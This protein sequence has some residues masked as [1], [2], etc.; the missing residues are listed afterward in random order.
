[1]G[2]IPPQS[3]PPGPPYGDGTPYGY[4][5]AFGY[6]CAYVGAG[7]GYD[8]SVPGYGSSY[9]IGGSGLGVLGVAAKPIRTDPTRRYIA[10]LPGL[11]YDAE[12]AVV[13]SSQWEAQLG[14]SAALIYRR[15]MLDPQVRS[16]WNYFVFAVLG[17]GPSITPAI[18]RAPERRDYTA[19]QEAD[20][21]L[22][23]AIAE[24][25]RRQQSRID[26][27]IVE[28]A[29]QF[30]HAAAYK[31]MLAEIVEEYCEVGPDAG[32][33]VLKSLPI[34]SPRSW[35][36]VVNA[37]SGET[38]GYLAWTSQG[39]QVVAPEHCE[40]FAWEPEAGDPRGTSLFEAAYSAW[41][42]KVSLVPERFKH[43]VLFG[44]PS[45]HYELPPNAQPYDRLNPD[46][47]PNYSLPQISPV[48]QGMEQAS[49]F[50]SGGIIVT[51][52]GGKVTIVG[53]QD[54]GGGFTKAKEDCNREIATAIL[55]SPRST[56]EA[57]HGS[58]ADNEGAQDS[59]GFLIQRGKQRLAAVFRAIYKRLV[60]ANWGQEVAD[61]L[62][63]LVSFSAEHHDRNA[64]IEANVKAGWKAD[65]T[66]FPVM[67][68]QAGLPVRP[69]VDPGDGGEI[70]D[71]E[72][73]DEQDEDDDEPAAKFAA[74]G[75]KKKRRPAVGPTDAEH[76]DALRF[77]RPIAEG[78]GLADGYLAG[79]LTPE[80]TR[81][82]LHAV[83][84]EAEARMRAEA[85]KLVA[86]LAPVEMAAFANPIKRFFQAAGKLLKTAFLAAALVLGGPAPFVADERKVFAQQVVAQEAF[87]KNFEAE[88]TSG[89]Q[90]VGPGLVNRAGM[91]GQATWAVGQNT[92]HGVM[93][94]RGKTEGR[95]VL[96]A[97]DDRNCEECPPLAELGWVPLKDVVP[98]G[99]TACRVNCRCWIEYRGKSGR[100]TFA[101][102]AKAAKAEKSKGGKSGKLGE[103][104]WVTHEG[105][106]LF[107]RGVGTPEN[108]KAGTP[109]QQKHSETRKA[110]AHS[111]RTFRGLNG[112]KG[113]AGKEHNDKVRHVADALL[114]RK[115]KAPHSR[116]PF[117]KGEHA[118]ATATKKAS[119]KPAKTAH[120]KATVKAAKAKPE[121]KAK[122]KVAEAGKAKPKA[123]KST[124]PPDKR[125]AEP[126]V[127][128][129]PKP[130]AT[131]PEKVVEKSKPAEKPASP[132]AE[133]KPYVQPKEPL[134]YPADMAP[135]PI[136]PTKETGGYRDF[137]SD[138]PAME[139]FGRDSSAA[140][141]KSLSPAERASIS[142]YSGSDYNLINAHYRD[143][144]HLVKSLDAR[145]ATREGFVKS[146]VGPL[147][148][149][150]L[151]ARTAEP[152][153]AYRGI[154]DVRDIGIDLKTLKKGS[155]FSEP[156]PASTSLKRETAETFLEDG[157]LPAILKI[158][159]PKGSKAAYLNAGELS[160]VA[161]E[162]ELLI[163]P[164]AAKYKVRKIEYGLE[165]QLI[166]VDL[167]P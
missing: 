110:L 17:D 119:A 130:K 161:Q 32:R 123:E 117:V 2:P 95:R 24:F 19:E 71:D 125:K 156:A 143:A 163:A 155:T 42:E 9:G 54:D 154:R 131:K 16:S 33:R 101:P 46:G 37:L 106:H 165:H 39:P 96:G 103:G 3:P 87:L 55:L 85:E 158:H 10:A 137:G 69:S 8:S 22:A 31:A 26:R 28:V 160:V 88:V 157:T 1:M 70:A 142:M 66:A 64:I 7:Y 135:T 12:A 51:H 91:Y 162:R 102:K 112:A 40:A 121:P 14:A 74:K 150:L 126:G 122:A 141:A 62:T 30:L 129:E 60:V 36:F 20:F 97:E 34:R 68:V 139:K 144:P 92:K 52:N 133:K 43:L 47:T 59:T 57:E 11:S 77:L 48:E 128:P 84:V 164:G 100:A 82:L 115:P 63:P 79:S 18:S 45:V 113:K 81:T 159:V 80:E 27:P 98:V 58:K 146:T 136:R 152:V 65:P 153:I 76:D 4:G 15:M 167:I 132:P 104:H 41:N 127:K 25:V 120:E 56:M 99:A 90:A 108:E 49:A 67:D 61:R 151:R 109:H 147:E 44:S 124:N 38:V 148:N 13:L 140:W 145:G 134:A 118:K 5:D 116:T 93:L 50:R 111:A 86:A 138:G 83:S 29:G 78:L 53:G 114:E 23:E 94:L 107:I 72:V 105:R 166:H 35:S 73:D 21:E 149:A 75:V 6:G 89:S